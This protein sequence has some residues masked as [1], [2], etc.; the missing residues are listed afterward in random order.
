MPVMSWQ[1][2]LQMLSS[3]A[4]KFAVETIISLFQD[5]PLIKSRK[6]RKYL[7]KRMKN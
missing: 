1:M 4:A 3:G 5:S 7:K 6:L 2:G